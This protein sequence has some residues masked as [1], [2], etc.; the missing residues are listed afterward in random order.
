MQ[1]YSSTR[2]SPYRHFGVASGAKL[3]YGEAEIEMSLP[4]HLLQTLPACDRFCS[5]LY[6]EV[7]I[8]P[9]DIPTMFK[10]LNKLAIFCSPFS[11]I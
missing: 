6:R 11:L 10:I 2:L 7:V 9:A 8:N 4:F 3:N 1:Y 5:P